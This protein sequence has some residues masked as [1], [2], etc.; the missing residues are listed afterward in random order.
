MFMP[1]IGYRLSVS[2]ASS[3]T[4]LYHSMKSFDLGTCVGMTSPRRDGPLKAAAARRPSHGLHG[5]HGARFPCPPCNPWPAGADLQP[6]HL[7]PPGPAM[8]TQAA[9]QPMLLAGEWT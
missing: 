6:F 4:S 5:F 2:S 7:F 3:T 1:L 8:Q 9:V